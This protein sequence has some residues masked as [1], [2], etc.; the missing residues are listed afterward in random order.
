MA[1]VT[2]WGL[3]V[4]LFL[5]GCAGVSDPQGA[6]AAPTAGFDETTGGITGTVL[7]EE[8]LPLANA[9]VG[10]FRDEPAFQSITTTDPEG[11]FAFSNLE[12]AR[13]RLIAQALGFDPATRNVDVRAG[14]AAA[15]PLVLTKVPVVQAYHHIIPFK[16]FFDCSWTYSVVLGATGPCGFTNL[17]STTGNPLEQFWTKSKRAWNYPVGPNLM[18]MI[19]ELTWQK[20]SFATGDKLAVSFS[21]AN[22]TTTHWYC[23]TVS[24][25]PLKLRWERDPEDPNRGTCP[26]GTAQLPS[27]QPTAVPI[28]GQIVRSYVNTGPGSVG[29][30]NLP[31]G[32]AYQQPFDLWATMFYG[33]SASSDFSAIPDT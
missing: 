18:T 10:L 2:R 32:L 5:S 23:N 6:P 12:P 28:K 17:N 25:N 9:Q 1:G 15:V 4:A 27:G 11:R 13:Y 22:R 26:T 14:E 19:N 3:A 20:G 29:G 31:V 8:Q 21:Y 33:Q 7:D 16:G 24:T 30:Q